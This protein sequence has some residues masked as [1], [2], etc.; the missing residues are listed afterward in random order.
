MRKV[1]TPMKVL[2]RSLVRWFWLLI[3]SIVIGFIVGSVVKVLVPATYQSVAYVQLSTQARTSQAQIIQPIAVYATDVTSDAVLNPVLSRYPQI[4]RTNFIAKQLV[5]TYDAPSQTVQIQVTVPGAKISAAMANQLAQLLVAQQNAAIQ[6][7]YTKA[8]QLLNARIADEQ[9][10]I[11]LLSQQYD[12]TP[13]TS[14]NVLTQLDNQIQQERTLQNNDIATQQAL[15][16]EQA[17][18]GSPLSIV[19][20]AT[21]ATKPSSIIGLI[22]ITSV[23]VVV[24]LVLG[25]VVVAIIEQSAGRIN[26]AYGLQEK[27]A[28][29]VLGTLRWTTPVALQALSAA[30]T[31]YAEDCRMMLADVLFQAE[32]EHIHTIA[33]TGTRSGAG[34]STIAAELALL[35][36]QSQRQVLLIDANMYQ[37]SIHTLVSVPNEAGLAKMLEEARTVRVNSLGI[38]NHSSV[39]LADRM[40]LDN[41]ICPTPFPGLYFLPAGKPRT[42]PSDL[43]NMPEMG[44]FLKWASHPVDF[45]IIDCPSLEHSEAHVLGALSDQTM[46]VIDATKDRLKFVANSKND[47]M[48]AG[49]KLSGVIVNKLGRWI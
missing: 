11:N 47:L 41:F 30:Q 22:P 32:T 37:P 16:T 25:I 31:P 23:M 10:Q 12:N 45:I 21:V 17:L 48:N 35:L 3:L 33:L 9:K 42:S 14:T 43:V 27:L 4:D 26:E 19:R 36:S 34:T 29:P 24:F 7:Q 44:Q 49:V 8:L 28:V 39:D 2:V 38:A 15:T 13:P 5:V 20:S 46:I 6:A 1:D 40:M 18:Y